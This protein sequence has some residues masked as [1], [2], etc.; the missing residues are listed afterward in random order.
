M[1]PALF[2]GRRPIPKP[3]RAQV[4]AVNASFQGLTLPQ[5]PLGGP[6]PMFG[7]FCYGL[8]AAGRQA[9]RNVEL[10]AK[11][12][13]CI[14]ALSCNYD[15]G[16]F[17]YTQAYGIPGCDFTQDLLGLKTRLAEDLTAG[18]LPVLYL[19]GDG[20]SHSVD[21]GTYGYPW[22][23]ANLPRIATALNDS[24]VCGFSFADVGIAVDGFELITDG[25]WSPDDFE[26]GTLATRAAFGPKAA[27]GSHIGTYTWWGDGTGSSRGP[28]GDWA[29][30]AGQAID[31][32]FEEGDVPFVDAN[33]QPLPNENADGW[34]QRASAR[35]GPEAMNILPKNV[36]EWEWPIQPATPRGERVSVAWEFDEYRWTRNQVAL[37][38]IQ[39]ERKYLASLSF[40]LIG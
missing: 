11:N 22:L 19:A 12:T 1:N 5:G 34:Q 17:S 35:Y 30:P 39:N 3:T 36:I 29:S 40:T 26:S 13:H 32:C 28:V 18:L 14:R 27:I 31:V 38:E 9:W 23:M 16:P 10:A 7:P 6:V 15:D 20:Q 33:S 4:I 24:T 37:S 2:G 25:G 21:G 8:D